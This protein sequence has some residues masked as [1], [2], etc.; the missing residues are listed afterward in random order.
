MT[1]N[2]RLAGQFHSAKR[3]RDAILRDRQLGQSLGQLAKSHRPSR[4]TIHRVLRE[5]AHPMEKSK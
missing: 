3:N 5:H 2:R 4:A 1:T